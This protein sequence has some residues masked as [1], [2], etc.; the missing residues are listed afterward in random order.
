[1]LPAWAG[2]LQ[3]SQNHCIQQEQ[4]HGWFLTPF[5]RSSACTESDYSRPRQ[6][7]ETGAWSCLKKKPFAK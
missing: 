7:I 5:Q 2:G 4:P 1:M 6:A 3:R